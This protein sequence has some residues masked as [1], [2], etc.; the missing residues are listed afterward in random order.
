M[1]KSLALIALAFVM[2]TQA[3]ASYIVVLKDGT[4]YKA[5]TKWTMSNGKALVALETGQTLAIDPS[6][7]D[8]AKSE[9]VTK[10]GL[11]D[12][13]I[14]DLNPNMPQAQKQEQQSLGSAIKLKKLPG[15]DPAAPVPNSS[16]GVV[17]VAGAPGQLGPDVMTKF[18]LAYENVGIFEHKFTPTGGRTMRVDLTADSEDKV[19]NALSATSFLMVRIATVVPGAQVDMVEIFMK[20]TTMGSSGRFQMTRAD[21]DALDQKKITLQDYFVRKVIF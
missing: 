15:Q 1:K 3:F 19:F 21:A 18:E 6:L 5:K 17:P 20:T 16:P 14:I 10:L 2:A 7:I 13:H 9:Q 12:A 8:V 11:G 4:Q